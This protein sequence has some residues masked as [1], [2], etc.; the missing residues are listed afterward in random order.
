MDAA[1]LKIAKEVSSVLKDVNIPMN[2][3]VTIIVNSE[4]FTVRVNDFIYG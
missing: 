1:Q 4:G 2:T 3:L